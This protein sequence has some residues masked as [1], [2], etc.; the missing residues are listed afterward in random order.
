MKIGDGWE[1][2]CILRRGKFLPKKCNHKPIT[3]DQDQGSIQILYDITD[4][5]LRSVIEGHIFPEGFLTP[6]H[7]P[8]ISSL[9]HLPEDILNNYED[10]LHQNRNFIVAIGFGIVFAILRFYTGIK[11]KILLCFSAFSCSLGSAVVNV[12]ANIRK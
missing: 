5:F 11:Y 3:H 8:N 9:D 4:I 6:E 2:H 1:L 7:Y 10:V 12:A